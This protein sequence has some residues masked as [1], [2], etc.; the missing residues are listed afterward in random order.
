VK[1]HDTPNSA[2]GEVLQQITARDTRVPFYFPPAVPPQSTLIHVTE[3]VPIH[4]KSVSSQLVTSQSK[5]SCA[6]HDATP[7]DTLSDQ[8]RPPPPR[9][10]HFGPP[11]LT[12]MRK[13]VAV[14]PIR[15]FSGPRHRKCSYVPVCQRHTLKNGIL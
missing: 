8:A 4:R 9:N 6:S 13:R 7:R 1:G 15:N 11:Y 12:V 5:G 3:S 2:V 14:V 10:N